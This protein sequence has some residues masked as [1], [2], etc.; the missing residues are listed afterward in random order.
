MANREPKT[1]TFKSM[2]SW[3]EFYFPKEVLSERISEL[4]ASSEEL[5]ITLA[6]DTID[7]HIERSRSDS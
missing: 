2:D 7:Q 5:G 6:N 1:E 4:S 3:R